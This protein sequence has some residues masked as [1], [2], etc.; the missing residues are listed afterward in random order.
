MTTTI[1]Y[2]RAKYLFPGLE[3]ID[4]LLACME[5]YTLDPTFED[6]G[7]FVFQGYPVAPAHV[8][9]SGNFHDAS[10]TFSIETDD[11]DLIDSII[12][13]IKANKAT[14]AYADA[15]HER[16][17]QKLRRQAREAAEK[18]AARTRRNER[19]DAEVTARLRAAGFDC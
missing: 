14:Q 10:A 3:S 13:A 18:L 4:A 7:D 6:Y 1:H 5:R 19:I 16:D 15:R 2:N 17:E 8:R 9:F 11:Q 12:A